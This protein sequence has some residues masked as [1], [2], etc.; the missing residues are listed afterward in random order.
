MYLYNNIARHNF[1]KISRHVGA[2]YEKLNFLLF[3]VIGVA[4]D[5]TETVWHWHPTEARLG[6]RP[7]Q[8]L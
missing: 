8:S 1:T 2:K 3:I 5:R 4:A 7:L 6:Q